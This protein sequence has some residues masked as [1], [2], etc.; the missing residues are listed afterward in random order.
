MSN[1]PL[2]KAELVEIDSHLTGSDSMSIKRYTNSDRYNV[3]VDIQIAKNN[4]RRAEKLIRN[5][6]FLIDN[7]EN[8]GKGL[9]NLYQHY[10]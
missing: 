8:G 2:T 4:D 1:E 7:F 5:H 10:R 6:R 3:I 9:V